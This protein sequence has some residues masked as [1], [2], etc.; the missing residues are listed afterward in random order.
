MIIIGCLTEKVLLSYLGRYRDRKMRG[1]FYFGT[2][3]LITI[4]MSK[5]IAKSS[6]VNFKSRLRD[7]ERL[8][9]VLNDPAEAS[10]SI[11]SSHTVV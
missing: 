7:L 11:S 4:K 6:Y 1:G 2:C 5:S 10:G 9:K 8:L 3:P